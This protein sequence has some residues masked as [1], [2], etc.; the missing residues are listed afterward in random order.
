MLIYSFVYLYFWSTLKTFDDLDASIENP[1]LLDKTLTNRKDSVND[2]L[3]ELVFYTNEE[4]NNDVRNLF[5][6]SG[7]KI[8]S[9]KELN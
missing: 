2:F 7:I 4:L 9:Q 8:Q 3:D 5:D 6:S 1:F